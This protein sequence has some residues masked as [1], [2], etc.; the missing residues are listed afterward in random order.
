MRDLEVALFGCVYGHSWQ[1]E[2]PTE[3]RIIDDEVITQ[4]EIE[5]CREFFCGNP[6]KTPERSSLSLSLSLSTAIC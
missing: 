6:V 1:Q 4:E 2:R 5:G 3:E